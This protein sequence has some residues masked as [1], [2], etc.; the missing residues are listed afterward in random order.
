MSARGLSVAVMDILSGGSQ[1]YLSGG[2][3]LWLPLWSG[4]R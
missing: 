4:L 2:A 3:R 1:L